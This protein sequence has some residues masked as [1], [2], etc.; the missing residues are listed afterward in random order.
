MSITMSQ[1]LPQ[2]A[3]LVSEFVPL[4]THSPNNPAGVIAYDPRAGNQGDGAS[5]SKPAEYAKCIVGQANATYKYIDNVTTYFIPV[6]ISTVCKKFGSLDF[7]SGSVIVSVTIVLRM[8]VEHLNSQER[9]AVR[10]IGL[11]VNEE[12]VAD[13]F[14]GAEEKDLRGI[15][16]FTRRFTLHIDFV[17][18]VTNF[19]FDMQDVRIKLELTSKSVVLPGDRRHTSVFRFICHH[20]D[21]P[22]VM[23]SF[24]HGNDPHVDI[25]D[26]IR[27]LNLAYDLVTVSTP[28]EFKLYPNNSEPAASSSDAQ[29]TPTETRV[30]EQQYF[31]I[32]EIKTPLFRAPEFVLLVSYFPLLI[33]NLIAVATFVIDPLDYSARLV[34][35]GIVMISLFACMSTYRSEIPVLAITSLDVSVVF[36]VIVVLLVIVDS[37]AYTFAT[38]YHVPWVPPVICAILIAGINGYIFVKYMN[39]LRK[40]QTMVGSG[41]QPK[42]STASPSFSPRYWKINSPPKESLL[43]PIGSE[44]LG[45]LQFDEKGNIIR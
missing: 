15:I 29:T 36:S 1:P 43:L 19:P 6:Y 39:Y 41:N 40:K 35:L 7:A 22:S 38:N 3:S 25:V 20:H 30:Y 42:V 28:P 9:D 34:I 10:R 12:E 4:N 44:V 5:S 14:G 11:R 16:S 27:G 2:D 8:L 33:L 37:F 21:T 26:R 45:I 32:V 18:S 31:P 13:P 17:P 23:V 24:K